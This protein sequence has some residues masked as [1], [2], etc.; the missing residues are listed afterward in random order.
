[1]DLTAQSAILAY[2]SQFEEISFIGGMKA[3]ILGAI[4]VVTSITSAIGETIQHGVKI[5]GDIYDQETKDTYLKE[6]VSLMKDEKRQAGIRGP[7]MVWAKDAFD[8]K[9]PAKQWSEEFK[10]ALKEREITK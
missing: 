8:W 6:L 4:P 9:I 10:R 5:P 1:M 7:M 2:P 3:Q